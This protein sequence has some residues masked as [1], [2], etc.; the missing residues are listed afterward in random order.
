MIKSLADRFIAATDTKTMRPVFEKNIERLAGARRKIESLFVTRVFPR[1]GNDFS[2][3]YELLL[4][5]TSELTSG[6]LLL[7]GRLFAAPDQLPDYIRK[8]EDS[9]ICLDDLGLVI[10]IFPF[11]P[12]LRH[13][14]DFHGTGP[15]V[16]EKLS[17]IAGHANTDFEIKGCDVIGYRL[18]RRCVILYSV[19]FPD[20]GA[21]AQEYLVAKVARPARVKKSL[22]TAAWLESSGFAG[23]SPDGLTSPRL[24]G[25]SESAGALL[26]EFAPG[27]SLHSLI[28]GA[29]FVEACRDAGKIL[30][31]LHSIR[32]R[33]LAVYSVADE[34]QNLEE[35]IGMVIGVFP[36]LKRSL[37]TA[38]EDLARS[39]VSDDYSLACVHRDY[40]DKQVLYAPDRV[41]LLDF[42][43]VALSDP[44]LDY[45][46][47]A[48][49]LCLRGL[50][51]PQHLSSVN[52]AWRAFDDGYG[53]RDSGFEE[54]AVWWNAAAMIRV[55]ALYSLRPRWR[56]LVENLLSGARDTLKENRV[57]SGESL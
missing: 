54:R 22:E 35:R 23:D 6:R 18:E 16:R 33:E 2:I 57:L 47:F 24:L 10:P 38:F 11:D 39:R 7:W 25:G 28:G 49:H 1:E 29:A 13:L 56:S 12:R 9:I 20:G 36:L 8:H 43:N 50:Q 5:S 31:K 4:E 17:I 26:M 40:Y 15:K 53:I 27:E 41:T 42:D 46:N 45:G 3:E 21:R 51:N 44:A 52:D 55:S 14:A 34:L 48:A 32:G 30:K 19:D 37:M